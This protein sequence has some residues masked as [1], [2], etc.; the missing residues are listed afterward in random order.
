M[1]YGVW[2]ID[3]VYGY[4]YLPCRCGHL[5]YRYG[6]RA[7]DMGDDSIDTINRFKFCFLN[8]LGPVPPGRNAGYAEH[9]R[10]AVPCREP[11]RRG[12]AVH[13]FRV[14]LFTVWGLGLSSTNE[15]NIC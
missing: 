11:Q 10:T 4:D 3:M 2:Y 1:V 12:K 15:T 8:Q 9:R 13:G 7:N 14:Q 6:L 5:G